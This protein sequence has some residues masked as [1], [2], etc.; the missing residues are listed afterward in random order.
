MG[1]LNEF[2]KIVRGHVLN[3]HNCD[4]VELGCVTG[5]LDAR[6]I[7]Q[8]QET[9]RSR[10]N[11]KAP[12]LRLTGLEVGKLS[13]TDVIDKNIAWRTVELR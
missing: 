7:G 10:A 6:N 8:C 4:P 1:P 13:A 3:V 11:A 5:R 12:L 2:L 9:L